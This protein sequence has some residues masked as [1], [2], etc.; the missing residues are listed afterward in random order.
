MTR[1]R[2][3]KLTIYLVVGSGVVA[4]LYS[5]APFTLFLL[6]LVG[7]LSLFACAVTRFA[8]WYRRHHQQ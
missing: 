5:L 8:A 4:V 3:L 7:G 1:E 6:G 2:L